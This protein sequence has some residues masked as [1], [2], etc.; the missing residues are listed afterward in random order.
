MGRKKDDGEGEVKEKG[1]G[2]VVGKLEGENPFF[3]STFTP[4]SLSP[5]LGCDREVSRGRETG[6]G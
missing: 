1:Q 6:V 3:P 4:T 2:E 5:P